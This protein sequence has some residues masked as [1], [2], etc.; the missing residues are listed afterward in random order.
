MILQKEKRL[1]AALDAM[2]G[3]E[4]TKVP[5]LGVI[6]YREGA[7]V[8]RHVA[9][10]SYMPEGKEMQPLPLLK[11]RGFALHLYQRCLQPLRLCSLSNNIDCLLIVTCADSWTY[12][13]LLRHKMGLLRSRCSSAIRHRYGMVLYMLFR[14]R[15][16]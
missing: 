3:D 8:Y 5:G 2:I 11:R 9:G 12:P 14:R 10:A 4:G 6:V 1:T 16:L 7:P 15:H 13:F